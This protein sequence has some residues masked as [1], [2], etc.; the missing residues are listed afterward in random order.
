[1]SSKGKRREL[2][3]GEGPLLVFPSLACE[4]G[5]NEAILLGQIHYW[6]QR[7]KNYRDGYYW[8]Y[9]SYTG[10]REQVPFMSV[11][12]IKR[13]IQRLEHDGYLISANYNKAGFDKTKWY[14]IDYSRI[15]ALPWGQIDPTKGS[16]W[17]DGRGQFEQTNTIDY[18]KTTTKTNNP[19]VGQLST[20]EL[21]RDFQDVWKQY[22]SKT[23]KQ[24]ALKHYVEW[25]CE[26]E[27]HTN[28]YLL[29]RLT[30]Y[31]SYLKSRDKKPM[32]GSTW[33]N[34]HFDDVECLTSE[35]QKERSEKI[36]DW[37]DEVPF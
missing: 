34:G 2:I 33:F 30:T 35:E 13:S 1:M 11:S 24:L 21:T 10:L 14:R 5:L 25:R 26:D 9:H 15:D 28:G 18:T 37:M 23:G 32:H 17:T 20:T 29:N 12:T 31:K 16:K 3:K 19:L 7:S 4:V 27:S 8:T 22:P 6:L 36:P